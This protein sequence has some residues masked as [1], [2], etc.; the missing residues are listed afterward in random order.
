M[1]SHANPVW[2]L[3]LPLVLLLTAGV[4]SGRSRLGWPIVFAVI[5]GTIVRA[6]VW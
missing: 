5:A 2:W 6:W 4:L 1:A 3:I